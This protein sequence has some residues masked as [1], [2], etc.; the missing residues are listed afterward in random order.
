MKEII[1]RIKLINVSIAEIETSI[2]VTEVS[3]YYK[4]FGTES[5]RQRDLGQLRLNLKDTLSI[6]FA[7]LESLQQSI[8][9]EKVDISYTQRSL[10]LQST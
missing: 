10:T 6:K 7:A 2:K 1:K 9:S 3:N 4:L 8:E 5:E